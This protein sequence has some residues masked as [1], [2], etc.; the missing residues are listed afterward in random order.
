MRF[1]ADECCD[2]AVVRALRAAGYDVLSVTDLSP[3]A[4]DSEIMKLALQEK[5]LLLTED[6]D[7]GRL[8]YAQ[9]QKVL[10]VIFL[11]FPL[12]ARK[13]IAK[14]VLKLVKQQEDKL[15]GCFVTV[16]PGQIRISR[17]P[18]GLKWNHGTKSQRQERK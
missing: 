5:R 12:S 10:G 3:R 17:M 6:K 13:Q 14:D 8:V 4:N 11:R 9:G 18:G 1:L 7:F 16:Q 2:Y 15:G